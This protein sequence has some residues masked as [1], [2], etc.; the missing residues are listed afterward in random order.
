M[1]VM[2][3]MKTIWLSI[4]VF[5]GVN[6][7]KVATPTKSGNFP[8]KLDL[9]FFSEDLGVE[10]GEVADPTLEVETV[11]P[12][13]ETQ[14][15]DPPQDDL[16]QSKAFAK[17]LEERTQR[18]LQEE[19]QK[20]EQETSQKYGNYDQYQQA[21]EF[22]M[23]RGGYQ[24]FDEFQ[25]AIQEAQLAERAEQNGIDPE[26]QSRVEQLEERA[27][28]ADEL[29]QRQQQEQTYQQFQS[30]LKDFSQ[31]KG[32]D[33]AELES[34]M[35][36]N[37]IANFEMAYRAWHYEQMQND[38]TN[39]KDVAVKEYLQSKKAP[40]VEGA[41]TPGVIKD[42]PPKNFEESRQRALERLRSARTNE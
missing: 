42:A 14:P 18:A 30:A 1:K 38:L 17:R 11:D 34:F 13:L 21:M 6:S 12:T 37:Q 26:F 2:R 20:W 4:L 7:R 35:V 9:Q 36:E 19:R 32:V 5:F 15:A 39:A 25:A 10:G 3:F 29:E 8:L 40:K 23:Q 33:P 28:L 27:R 41:G 31:Q 24:S 22:M 16:E